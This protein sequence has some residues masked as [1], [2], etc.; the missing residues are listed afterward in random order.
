MGWGV[1]GGEHGGRVGGGGWCRV[2]LSC[3]LLTKSSNGLLMTGLRTQGAACGVIISTRRVRTSTPPPCLLYANIWHCWN[4]R[5][6]THT[7]TCTEDWYAQTRVCAW[8]LAHPLKTHIH[9]ALN[10]SYN[11]RHPRPTGSWCLQFAQR[12][13]P[14]LE[15][16]EYSAGPTLKRRE[17]GGGGEHLLY[18]TVFTPHNL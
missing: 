4:T 18:T 6:H 7:H 1:G 10:I 16:Q 13:K 17:G 5:T 8:T 9:T 3:H 15:A 11:E 14:K 2:L 12:V